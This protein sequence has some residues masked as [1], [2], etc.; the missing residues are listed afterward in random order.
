MNKIKGITFFFSS[1]QLVGIHIHHSE[2]SCAMDT[3]LTLPNRLQRAVVWIYLPISQHDPVLVLGIREAGLVGEEF[4]AVLVRTAFVG[5]V[6]IASRPLSGT[7]V[8]DRCLAVSTPVTMI[9]SE[10]KEGRPVCFFG[11]RCGPLPGQPLPAPFPL[12]KP[13]RWRGDHRYLSWAPLSGV[14]STVVFHDQ[15]T[16]DCRGILFHY[17]NGGCRTVGQC[18]L[19]VDLAESVVRPVQFR[20]RLHSSPET[21]LAQARFTQCEEEELAEG[22]ESRPMKGLVE[23]WST[24]ESTVLTIEGNEG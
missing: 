5:D 6:I 22:W 18:R 9:D 1:G 16:G 7:E 11:S 21:G 10:P 24:I 14:S 19:G 4:Q 8:K 2:S 15:N 12:G 17:Q 13:G 20:F 23:F 3:F